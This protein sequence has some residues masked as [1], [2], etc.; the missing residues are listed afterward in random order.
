MKISRPHYLLASIQ[1]SLNAIA[2][3]NVRELIDSLEPL[4]EHD[5]HFTARFRYAQ[6]EQH[7][8][9]RFDCWRATV[10]AARPLERLQS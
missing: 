10:D 5:G 1:L 3:A 6:E 4:Q 9:A 2:Q 7:L 8:A